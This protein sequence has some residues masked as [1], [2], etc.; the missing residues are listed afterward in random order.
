ML[1][2]AELCGMGTALEVHGTRNRNRCG[3]D[4]YSGRDLD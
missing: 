3:Q 1:G 2:R 4:T